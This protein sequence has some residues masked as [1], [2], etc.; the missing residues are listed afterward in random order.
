ME[1]FQFYEKNN[2][3]SADFLAFYRKLVIERKIK[4]IQTFPWN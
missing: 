2:F 1:F 3:I 4:G